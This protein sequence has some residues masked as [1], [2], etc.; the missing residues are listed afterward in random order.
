MYFAREV[1][2]LIFI[3]ESET[4]VNTSLSISEI[5]HT[6]SLSRGLE[7]VLRLKVYLPQGSSAGNNLILDDPVKGKLDSGRRGSDF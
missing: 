1:G 6:V 2:D 7:H 4:A 3:T 5:D